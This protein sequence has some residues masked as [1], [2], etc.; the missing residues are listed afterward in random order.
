[1]NYIDLHAHMVSRTTDDYHKMALTGCLAVTEPAFWSGR[2]RLGAQ[3]FA[4]YFDHI[5]TFEPARARQYGIAHYAWLCLNPKEGEDRA[6]AREVL[7]LIPEYLARP[8]VLG[9]GE[10]GL[11]RVTRNELA[12]FLD[13]VELALEHDQLI[14]IHTPHLEDKYKGT[15]VI[16]ETLAKDPR[17]QPHRVMVDHAEEHTADLILEHGFWTGFTLY[18]KTK[19]SPNRAIDMIEMHGPER[20]C[21]ASACDWG[22]SDPVAVPEF[23]LEMRRRGHDE[24]LIRRIVLENPARFLRQSPK[25]VVPREVG[26]A[27]AAD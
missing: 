5:T 8:T 17:I 7:A 21:V 26:Q 6:L 10:I 2:D 20:I 3:A 12:T 23:V 14:H 19:A 11:N 13:H 1:M 18:P 27:V 4:D 24:E 9:I 25:F 22:P 16:V 15:K